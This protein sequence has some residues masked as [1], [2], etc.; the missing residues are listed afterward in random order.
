MHVQHVVLKLLFFIFSNIIQVLQ[1]FKTFI[2]SASC[3]IAYVLP[4]VKQN[5]LLGAVLRLLLVI[6]RG[7]V[8]KFMNFLFKK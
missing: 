6:H 3:I 7:H 2:I 4:E 1:P 8:F 5:D